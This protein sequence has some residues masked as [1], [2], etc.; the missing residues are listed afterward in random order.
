MENPPQVKLS[1]IK[2]K[3]QKGPVFSALETMVLKIP[4]PSL[5]NL[6]NAEAPKKH[7]EIVSSKKLEG[8]VSKSKSFGSRPT[9][10]SQQQIE[11]I[12]EDVCVVNFFILEFLINS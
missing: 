6:E 7:N 10:R 3:H 9:I 11:F 4:D 8:K 1:I 5:C 2:I 12:I